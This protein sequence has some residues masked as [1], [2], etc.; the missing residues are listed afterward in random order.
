MAPQCVGETQPA[1]RLTGLRVSPRRCAG[2]QVGVERGERLVHVGGRQSEAERGRHLPRRLAPRAG[3]DHRQGL[4]DAVRREDQVAG[5]DLA[6]VGIERQ[7]EGG[8][9]GDQIGRAGGRCG[10]RGASQG[11][12][13]SGQDG[14]SER[15]GLD[16]GARENGTT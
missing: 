9:A 2:D 14:G 4:R 1:R 6:Q 3:V 8:V 16:E 7:R 13:E 10:C 5:G 11:R 12:A 15:G